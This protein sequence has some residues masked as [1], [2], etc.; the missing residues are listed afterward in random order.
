MNEKNKELACMYIYIYMRESKGWVR[1]EK[2]RLFLSFSKAT[3]KKYLLSFLSLWGVTRRRDHYLHCPLMDIY[4]C[5]NHR[6]YHYW[7]SKAIRI[8]YIDSI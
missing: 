3:V 5:T 4:E 1:F 6:H 8:D 7:A 2:T